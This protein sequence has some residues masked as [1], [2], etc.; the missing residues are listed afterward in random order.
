VRFPESGK[1]ELR[2]MR[3]TFLHSI[4]LGKADLCG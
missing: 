1:Y 3:R 2:A 4:L